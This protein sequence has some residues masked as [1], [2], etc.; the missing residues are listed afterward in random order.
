MPRCEIAGSHSKSVSG[1]VRNH[2]LSCSG[3]CPALPTSPESSWCSRPSPASGVVRAL[4]LGLSNRGVYPGSQ[5]EW[6]LS[7]RNFEGLEW[8]RAHSRIH[9]TA[10]SERLMHQDQTIWW[11]RGH[12]GATVPVS[13]PFLD[14]NLVPRKRQCVLF[15]DSRCSSCLH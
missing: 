13:D 9:C 14:G 8:N 2:Q 12:D 15:T 7:S 4:G 5:C 10:G 3:G 11:G 6:N 1:F